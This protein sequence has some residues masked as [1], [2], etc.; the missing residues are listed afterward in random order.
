MA[1]FTSLDARFRPEDRWVAERLGT[2]QLAGNGL[3]MVIDCRMASDARPSWE[4]V[5]KHGEDV[6][7]Y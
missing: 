6:K 2:A 3:K 4:E 5:R 7:E 1:T